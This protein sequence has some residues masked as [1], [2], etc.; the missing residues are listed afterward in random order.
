MHEGDPAQTI[1]IVTFHFVPNYGAVW[2]TYALQEHLRGLGLGVE[3]VDYR[4][5]HVF[6]GGAFW[7]PTSKWRVQADLVIAFQKYQRLRRRL[8]G[9]SDLDAAFEAFLRERL[10]V[11]PKRYTTLRSLRQDPPSYDALVCGSDQIW[12]PSRQ[13][14]TDPAY[15]L[16]FAKPGQRTVAYAASFGRASV[17]PRFHAQIGPLIA[18]LDRVSVREGSGVELARSLSKL[19]DIVAM[20]DPT[21]LRTEYPEAELPEGLPDQYLFSYVLRSGDAV[22]AAQRHL[23]GRAGLKI[24]TPQTAHGTHS[25]SDIQRVF[26]PDQWLGAIRGSAV[27]VTNSFHGT[28]FSILF[29]RP[30]LTIGIGSG[31]QALNERAYALLD[32]LGLIERLVTGDDRQQLERLADTPIDWDA[33]AAKLAAWRGEGDTFLRKALGLTED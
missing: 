26:T 18:K 19:D 13:F 11:S 29:R 21:L 23:A 10:A 16:D 25:E 31:K 5:S 14:G 1:G 3:V 2:Q 28:I 8:S 20:P 30:F 12:N 22:N 24:V 33:V 6:D 9:R 32:R 27:V 7:L 15:F 17:E 4:P